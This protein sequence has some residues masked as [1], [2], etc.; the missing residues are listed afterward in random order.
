MSMKPAKRQLLDKLRVVRA[1]LGD[2]FMFG[3]VVFEFFV[4][5]LEMTERYPE[6]D[7]VTVGNARLY[8]ACVLHLP[9]IRLALWA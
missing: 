5:Q 9:C 4:R 3:W 8:W 2:D 1:L 6:L 7:D